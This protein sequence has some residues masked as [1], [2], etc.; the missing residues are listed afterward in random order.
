MLYV[1]F[2][3][4]VESNLVLL[5][6]GDSKVDVNGMTV[7]LRDGMQVEVY[8]DDLD[9]NGNVDNLIATG[10]V[11]KN[12]ATGWGQHVKWCC[13]IDANGIRPQSEIS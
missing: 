9:G 10:V 1:D 7:V 13:R 12:T 11:E 3:E 2:N 4:M 6:A 5:S 8:M